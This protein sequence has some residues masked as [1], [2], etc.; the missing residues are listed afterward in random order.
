[1]MNPPVNVG[2]LVGGRDQN[3]LARGH[4]GPR[5]K[6]GRRLHIISVKGKVTDE[7]TRRR[8]V[9]QFSPGDTVT[10]TSRMARR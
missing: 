6:A 1:M 9:A 5:R 3:N 10:P 2:A 4:E 8:D 7:G